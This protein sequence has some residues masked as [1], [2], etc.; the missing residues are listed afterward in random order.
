MD[1]SSLAKYFVTADYDARW[2]LN[3]FESDA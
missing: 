1:R 3:R 2:S